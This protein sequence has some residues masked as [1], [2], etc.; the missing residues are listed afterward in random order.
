M[1][2]IKMLLFW[3]SMVFLSVIAPILWLFGYNTS[4]EFQHKSCMK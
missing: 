4:L 3:I 1:K 2:I